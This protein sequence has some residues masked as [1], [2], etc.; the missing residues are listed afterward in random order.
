[1]KC[2]GTYVAMSSCSLLTVFAA[3]WVKLSAICKYDGSA[4]P[5]PLRSGGKAVPN[6]SRTAAQ[7]T[8]EVAVAAA[9]ATAAERRHRAERELIIAAAMV[10]TIRPAGKILETAM[11]AESRRQLL[12]ILPVDPNGGTMRRQRRGRHRQTCRRQCHASQQSQDEGFHCA[13]LMRH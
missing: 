10:R 4:R 5:I 9:Q 12:R 1:M 11:I 6:R 8:A 2:T 13:S 7:Q 3:T